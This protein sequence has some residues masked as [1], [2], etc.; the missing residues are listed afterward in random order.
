PAAQLWRSLHSLERLPPVASPARCRKLPPAWLR[1]SGCYRRVVGCL[2]PL[3]VLF[4]DLAEPAGFVKHKLERLALL[5]NNFAELLFLSK[6]NR[7]HFYHFKDG[8][9][10]DDHRMSRGASFKEFDQAN[11]VVVA[12]EN[13]GA[14]L[15]H[16]LRDGEGW[17]LQVDARDFFSAFQD[18]LEDFD[19]I[20]QR[21]D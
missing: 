4:V 11:A 1:T 6:R 15:R 17:V 8:E 2:G 13:L 3:F 20:D 10:R 19:E 5:E 14:K 16:H 12:G 9:K 7:L 18:L 21:D